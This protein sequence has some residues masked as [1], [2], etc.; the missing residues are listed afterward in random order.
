[1]SYVEKILLPDERIL[2]ITTISSIVYLEGF[3]ITVCGGLF[4][5]FAPHVLHFLVRGDSTETLTRIIGGIAFLIALVGAALML[6]AYAK[7][8]SS[9]AI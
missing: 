4:A 3:T 7:Q 9:P 8:V 5:Y 2:C 1:M 6:F